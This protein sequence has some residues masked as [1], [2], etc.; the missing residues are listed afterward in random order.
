[1]RKDKRDSLIFKLAEW[2]GTNFYHRGQY[3]IHNALQSIFSL[4][5][6]QEYSVLRDGA[7]WVLNPSDYVHRD[8]F[9]FGKKDMWDVWHVKKIIKPNSTILDVG[10]NFGYYSIILAL[11]LMK[12]CQIYAF[13]P[14]LPVFS[15]LVR[16]IMLND[17]DSC[18]KPLSIA[19]SD[20]IG[21]GGALAFNQGN[22]G[23]TF[24]DNSRNGDIQMTTVDKFCELNSGISKVDFI[25]IDVEGFELFVLQGA[26]QVI[27]RD[28][29]VVFLEL[30]PFCL[31]RN[32]ITA[33]S[34]IELLLSY[35]YKLFI[36]RRKK[37]IPFLSVNMPNENNYVNL[38]AFNE[39]K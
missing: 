13:E 37:L 4:N 17:L 6:D 25:K 26:R 11:E 12:K 29:P 19:L 39:T 16:N 21:S 27:L 22:S 7:K 23:A 36:S 24:I 35:G 1:M 5:V 20:K 38:F 30:N 14:C 2:Y 18:I 31:K 9:W 15:R 34:L 28:K 33:N 3:I 10:A 8:V 32:R